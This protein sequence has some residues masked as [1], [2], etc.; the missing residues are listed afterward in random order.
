MS[1]CYCDYDP[2]E[3]Y[4][5]TT[6]IARQPHSCNECGGVI[7]KGEKYERV[8]GVWCGSASTCKTCQRCID[9]RQ[10][11]T[12]HIQCFCWA[13]HNLH[14]DARECAEQWSHEAPGLRFGTLRRMVI[15]RNHRLTTSP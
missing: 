10:F 5:A 1:D 15:A 14:A 13:H 2:A 7:A 9:L 4:V 6:P 11:V 3:V 12:D 8:F